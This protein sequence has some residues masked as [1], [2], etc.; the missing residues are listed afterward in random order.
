[1]ISFFLQF[2]Y[3][4]TNSPSSSL[5]QRWLPI[6]ICWMYFCPHPINWC[7]WCQ[8]NV[9]RVNLVWKIWWSNDDNL[10]II[11][12]GKNCQTQQ[13][14]DKSSFNCSDSNWK[15]LILL[16]EVIFQYFI[17]AYHA[18][19]SYKS[20]YQIFL[21]SFHLLNFVNL[22]SS[23]SLHPRTKTFNNHVE[24]KINIIIV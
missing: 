20:S 18:A 3:T 14:K 24:N 7:C 17:Y 12:S 19:Q 16:K 11:D 6:M 15:S 10:L 8:G 21:S 4:S 9:S 2:N 5:I 22:C 13:T 1:M 23:S